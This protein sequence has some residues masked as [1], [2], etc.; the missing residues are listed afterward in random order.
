MNKNDKKKEVIDLIETKVELK[1]SQTFGNFI[2]ISI[3]DGTKY[4]TVLDEKEFNILFNRMENIKKELG[5]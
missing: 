4:T 2:K 1:K 3:I 5:K